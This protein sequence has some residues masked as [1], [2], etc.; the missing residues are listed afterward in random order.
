MFRFSIRDVPWLVLVAGLELLWWRDHWRLG[1]A[2]EKLE[3]ASHDYY[4]KL[5]ELSK[6]QNELEQ[7][8]AEP[9]P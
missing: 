8:L 7:R 9:T 1:V 3:Q 6:L 5:H 4:V 2:A